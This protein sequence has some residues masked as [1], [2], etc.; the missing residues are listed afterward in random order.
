MS[1]LQFSVPPLLHYIIG[2]HVVQTP[3]KKH[4][5]RHNIKVFDLLFVARGCLYIGEDERRYEV[6]DGQALI[7]RPD[8]SH[9]GLQ[10]CDSITEYYWIHFQTSGS[11]SVSDDA[12]SSHP[13]HLSALN[14]AFPLFSTDSFSLELPQYSSVRQ[15]GKMGEA[16]AGLTQ[17]N[18]IAHLRAS[19]FKQQMMFQEVAQ[20]LSAS[21]E[22]DKSAPA[23]ACAE[24][25]AAYLR[26]HYKEEITAGRL[27]EHL[28][29]HPVY[30]ARCMSK[31]YGCSPMEYL[32]R[33]RIE[34][35]KLMLLR[36]DYSVARIAE[37]SG[38]N[39]TPYFSSC[40]MRVEGMSPRKYRQL[41]AREQSRVGD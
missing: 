5:S 8:C 27:G 2:G 41:F 17:L 34:Q 29:F 33:Y 31:E 20:L 25:A 30:V 19:R 1:L 14:P 23:T 40:F 18:P 37:E 35:S 9:Y 22:H 36:T 4:V 16:L 10:D 7:L 38:F 13:S 32:L 21:L 26:E 28:S 24:S 3:G 6:T 39:Q 11:W 15:P 12:V